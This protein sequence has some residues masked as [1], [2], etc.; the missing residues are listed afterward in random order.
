MFLF[1]SRYSLEN[2]PTSRN[3]AG[4]N[5]MRQQSYITAV[6]SANQS[7]QPD[8]GKNFSMIEN[9]NSIFKNSFTI[10]KSNNI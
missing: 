9:L 10:W 6:R 5:L 3:S 2:Y 1:S 8:F 7:G 4:V